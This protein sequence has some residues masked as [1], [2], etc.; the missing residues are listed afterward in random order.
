MSIGTWM[1][2]DQDLKSSVY[3][4]N[5]AGIHFTAYEAVFAL[6]ANLVVTVVL[7]I[8]LRGLGVREGADET[9]ADDYFE[10]RQ[11]TARPP[12]PELAR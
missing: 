3:A 12:E 9:R 5:W 11:E 10:L 2:A 6:V 4:L 7:T 1:A 8:V